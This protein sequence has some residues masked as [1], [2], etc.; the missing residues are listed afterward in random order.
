M[1]PKVP[2]DALVI[3]AVVLPALG[4]AATRGDFAACARAGMRPRIAWGVA[5]APRFRARNP[6]VPA[7]LLHTRGAVWGIAPRRSGGRGSASQRLGRQVIDVQMYVVGMPGAR[8]R[9]PEHAVAAGSR[10]TPRLSAAAPRH[11]TSMRPRPG[12]TRTSAWWH[13]CTGDGGP[14][15]R[16]SVG[17]R[18]RFSPP[19]GSRHAGCRGHRERHDGLVMRAKAGTSRR[20]NP[21]CAMPATGPVPGRAPCCA[22]PASCQAPSTTPP[23][24]ARAP[25]ARA[26][27]T[28]AVP[29]AGAP[30]TRLRRVTG[31]LPDTHRAHDQHIK[32]PTQARQEHTNSS[33]RTRTEAMKKRHRRIS[34]EQ[35]RTNDHEQQWKC[36]THAGVPAAR[37][38]RLALDLRSEARHVTPTQGCAR[39]TAAMGRPEG[40]PCSTLRVR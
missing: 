28:P 9:A 11:G 37:G 8:T 3:S 16:S 24:T 39:R 12:A 36:S 2:S 18:D 15:V 17:L 35:Q 30:A 14:T 27:R 21:A 10:V 6:L 33:G 38:R 34:R 32:K 22:R 4:P 23:D 20:T 26:R 40:A 19:S 13:P 5:R 1:R 25:R 7:R 29:P 31:H